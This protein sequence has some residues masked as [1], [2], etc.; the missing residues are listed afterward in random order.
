M[1]KLISKDKWGF[2]VESG[3]TFSSTAPKNLSDLFRDREYEYTCSK[4]R[5][6]YFWSILVN[7]LKFN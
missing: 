1:R 6:H 2:S 3:I 4:F 7:A 5:K